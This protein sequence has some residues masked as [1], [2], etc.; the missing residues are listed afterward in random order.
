MGVTQKGVSSALGLSRSHVALELKKLLEEGHAETRLAHVQGARSRRKVYFLSPSGEGIASS[1]RKRVRD[2]EAHWI[3]VEGEVR[4]GKGAELLQICRGLDRP[5]TPVYDGLLRGELVDL[6][7]AGRPAAP[8]PSPVMV[9]RS[10][11][12]EQLRTWLQEGPRMLV[13]TGLPGMGKTVLA[14]ALFRQAEN[15]VWIKVFPFHSPSSLLSS[16]AHGLASQGRQRLL[17]YLGGGAPDL[18]EVGFLLSQEAAGLLLVFDDAASTSASDV[19][20]LFL[21]NPAPGCR[22]LLTARRQPDFL[23]AE[24]FLSGE[25][26]EV[27]LGGLNLGECRELLGR[28]GRPKGEA[29]RVFQLTR[30]HP[31]LIQLTATTSVL[32]RTADVEASFL[33]EVLAG[34][35][36]EEEDIL[37]RASVYRRPFSREALGR[38]SV[39]AL[40]SLNRSGLLSETGGMYEV[41]DILAPLIRRHG[42]HGLKGAHLRASGYWKSQGEWLEALY[43]TA[44]VGR[45]RRF[46]QLAEERLDHV[47]ERGQADELLGLL[48]DLPKETDARLFYLKARALDYLG[49]W[50]EAHLSLE[51]GMELAS[52]ELRILMLLAEG[53]LQSKRGALTEAESAFEA[54]AELSSREGRDL[55]LG[56]ARYGLGIVHRKTGNL[57]RALDYL[58]E[59]RDIFEGLGADVDLGRV[60]M[61][62]GV[63]QLQANRPED[64][65]RWFQRSM[66]LLSPRGVDSA[67]LKNNLG[68]AYS[69]LSRLDESLKAFE[70]SIELAER[71]GMVRA[72]GYAL[73]NA[74]D[75]YIDFGKIDRALDYCEES[76]RIFRRLEDPLMISACF[77]NQAKAERATGNLA[78]AKKLYDE[79]FRTLE[80]T[81]APYSLAAR[82]LEASDLYEEMGESSRA[83]EL[84]AKALGVLRENRT[85]PSST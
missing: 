25:A 45:T 83:H 31:L 14:K 23:R 13:V 78:E 80:G 55:E 64:A 74:S 43:H 21:E 29:E 12:L 61:E 19:L 20:R 1:L 77:A 57:E 18:A 47:L 50:R 33:D 3:D 27:R 26:T 82:W 35:D 49:R 38:A 22:V 9:G 2:A 24:D 65:V 59:A 16:V 56:R 37:A 42:G 46:L 85:F 11:E 67:F 68:I 6:R 76:L 44:A 28:L 66:P 40:R 34:L 79:S 75:L 4:E 52:S 53:R 32:P 54:A 5:M 10:K 81:Q 72:R 39:R 73:A 8:P 69:K 70:E 62:M 63:V 58:Q 15:G 60:Q 30:G 84:R 41:H 71:T 48:E 36:S 51:E 17:S 7:E